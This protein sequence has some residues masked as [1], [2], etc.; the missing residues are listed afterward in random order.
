V[1]FVA[2]TFT[3]LLPTIS[4]G[5]RASVW[6]YI[7]GV[8]PHIGEIGLEWHLADLRPDLL[9]AVLLLW[10]LVPLIECV[11]NLDRRVWLT[12]GAFGG[13]AVLVKASVSPLL[14]FASALTIAYVF[15]VN[16][17]RLSSSVLTSLWS[18]LPFT[19][20]SVP[21]VWAG[22]ARLTFDYIY[23]NAFTAYRAVWS[24]PDATFLS[25]VA[26]Y[27]KF[28]PVHI[29]YVEGWAMLIIGLALSLFSFCRRT[30]RK[31][32]R[33][34]AYLGM[35]AA[36]YVFMSAIPNKSY[37]AGL[38]YYLLLW[39]FSWMVLSS[40][41]GTR[42]YRNKVVPWLLVLI[43]CVY[44]GFYVAGGFYSLQ[45]WPTDRRLA[46][47][48]N[49]QVVQHIAMDMRSLLTNNDRFMWAPAY[50][51]PAA[52]QYYMI[53][54]EG[55]YPQT[56]WVDIEKSPDRVIRESVSTCKVILAY[57]ED[58]DEVARF[59]YVHPISRPYFRAIA[60]WVKQPNSSYRLVKTYY[61]TTESGYLTLH[62]YLRQSDSSFTMWKELEATSEKRTSA[63]LLHRLPNSSYTLML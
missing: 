8:T 15:V 29:G 18:L 25:E 53:D 58:I 32:S 62:L 13:L 63:I 24:N 33:I 7:A 42:A 5:L 17:R 9:F 59:M 43:L 57:E 19:I 55:Q 39:I 2:A 30:G 12:S 56:I 34:I 50:G 35:S 51:F 40:F 44:A 52:L 1:G 22:G 41:L 4:V 37:F 47:Q 14:F 3:C 26:Y 11:H 23:A 46:M 20:L 16:R 10:S 49:R 38:S 28:F 54:E 61:F 60:E 48:E 6:G 45:N 21:W 31:D 36:L 27:W